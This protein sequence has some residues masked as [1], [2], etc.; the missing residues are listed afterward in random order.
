MKQ[1]LN[2]KLLRTIV[3]YNE[4]KLKKVD[5]DQGRTDGLITFHEEVEGME[6]WNPFKDITL[7]YDV[8]PIEEYGELKLNEMIKKYKS[9]LTSL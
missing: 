6:I 3:E 2:E 5:Y 1:Q 7:R 8:D 4:Q 9:L